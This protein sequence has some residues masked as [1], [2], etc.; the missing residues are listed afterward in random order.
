MNPS[1]RSEG[2]GAVGETRF[3]CRAAVCIR[4]AV[5]QGRVEGRDPWLWVGFFR[6]R[7]APNL[8]CI[9]NADCF[10]NG[11]VQ[12]NAAISAEKS[13]Q[14]LLSLGAWAQSMEF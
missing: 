2:S 14:P 7:V 9:L 12:K 5:S 3:D 4:C 8:L 10:L 1:E 11:V 13:A 6:H